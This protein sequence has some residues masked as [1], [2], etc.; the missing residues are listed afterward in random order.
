MT[1]TS[2]T[3]NYPV[4]KSILADAYID[5][6]CREIIAMNLRLS[7]EG[8]KISRKLQFIKLRVIIVDIGFANVIYVFYMMEHL[9]L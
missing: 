3:I 8:Q 2:N 4:K 5:F 7:R 1:N 9:S 6:L